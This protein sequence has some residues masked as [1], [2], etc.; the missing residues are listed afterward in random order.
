MALGRFGRRQ[1]R[2]T[3]SGEHA[4]S[5]G[6]CSWESNGECPYGT[7]SYSAIGSEHIRD[8]EKVWHEMGSPTIESP[9]S[10]RSDPLLTYRAE[11]QIL[12]IPR[13]KGGKVV[14]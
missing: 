2:K 1:K 14:D 6:F 12:S 8:K 3:T 10:A 5:E 9:V 13:G 7:F 4:W 11:G